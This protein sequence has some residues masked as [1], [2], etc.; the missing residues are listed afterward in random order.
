MK[1]LDRAGVIR[2]S[3]SVLVHGVVGL[4]PVIG[5]IPAVSAIIHGIRI[6]R[7]YR[8]PNPVDSYRKW[9]MA[10]GCLSVLVNGCA[11]LILVINADSVVHE[12]LHWNG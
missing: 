2:E 5:I 10:L 7:A 12:M 3:V 11:T 4:V 6:S 9:G 1:S 8:E